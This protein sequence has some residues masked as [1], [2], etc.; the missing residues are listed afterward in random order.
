MTGKTNAGSGRPFAA[1][2][3]SYPERAECICT[4]GS[5]TFRAGDGKGHFLFAIPRA[6]KWTLKAVLEGEEDS[7]QLDVTE[8]RAYTAALSFA[9][10]LFGDGKDNSDITGGWEGSAKNSADITDGNLGFGLSTDTSTYLGMTCLL[11][12]DV[13]DYSQLKAR[14][15]EAVIPTECRFGLS[16]EKGGEPDTRI[17]I[18]NGKTGEVSLD[19]SQV[20]GSKYITVYC[21]GP[22]GSYKQFAL[23]FGRIWLE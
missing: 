4:D 3:V 17:L 21:P 22:A 12:I 19:I 23:R 6:G 13:T 15:T 8:R 2:D 11:P 1:I 9:L 16:E 7:I 14:V 5:C 18:P 20:M 10:E